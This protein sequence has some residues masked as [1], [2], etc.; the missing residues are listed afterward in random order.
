MAILTAFTLT[1][2]GYL[3]VLYKMTVVFKYLVTTAE[4]V[5]ILTALWIYNDLGKESN[6]L[7]GNLKDM[8]MIATAFILYQLSVLLLGINNDCENGLFLACNIIWA[9]VLLVSQLLFTLS[10]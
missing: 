5:L 10:I 1:G 6:Y 3:T 9:L 4:T 7:V 8:Y 2:A